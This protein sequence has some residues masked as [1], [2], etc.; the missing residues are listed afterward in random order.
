MRPLPTGATRCGFERDGEV[1][2][3][4]AGHDLVNGTPHVIISARTGKVRVVPVRQRG[5]A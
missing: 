3:R 5:A 2:R 4:P 1:C